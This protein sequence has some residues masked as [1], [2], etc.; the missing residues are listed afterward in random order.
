LEAK[1]FSIGPVDLRQSHQ[2]VWQAR[3]P[4]RVEEREA[5]PAKV[6]TFREEEKA[7]PIGCGENP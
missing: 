1:V 7:L 4:L 2:Q 3:E 5:L 6:N